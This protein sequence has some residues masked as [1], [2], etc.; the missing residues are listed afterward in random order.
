MD[1]HP[2]PIQITKY[3]RDVIVSSC[4]VNKPCCATRYRLE[5]VQQNGGMTNQRSTAII[6]TCYIKWQNQWRHNMPADWLTDAVKLATAKQLETVRWT[7]VRINNSESTPTPRSRTFAFN[8]GLF[9]LIQDATLL[10]H[11]DMSLCNWVVEFG[12]LYRGSASR[13]RR[14][15]GA[16]VVS[17]S[18]GRSAVY[19][20]R[21][22]GPRI[23]PCG[24]H[25]P[26]RLRSTWTLRGGQIV[27][28]GWDRT[29]TRRRVRQT[30][31]D[32]GVELRDRQY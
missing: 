4:T 31:L 14:Y 9:D 23:D 24:P 2:Q 29:Q 17:A 18:R 19:R 5:S 26:W 12:R 20:R 11:A 8:C 16:S 28:G 10:M 27:C 15:A 22:I 21:R 30:H 25:T 1:Q 6:K 7:C 13:R 32:D 3:R